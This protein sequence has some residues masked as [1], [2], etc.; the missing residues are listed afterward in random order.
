MQFRRRRNGRNAG[1]QPREQASKGELSWQATAAQAARGRSPPAFSRLPF[2]ARCLMK[3]MADRVVTVHAVEILVRVGPGRDR[4]DKVTVTMQA[5]SLRDPA[6]PRLDLNRLVEVSHR[7]GPRM[8]EPIIGLGDPFPDRIVREVAI[9]ADGHMPVARL[10]PRIEMSL[11]H[12]TIHAGLRVVTQVARPFSIAE[13]E[14]PHA[15]E[16]PCGNGH[17]RHDYRAAARPPEFSKASPRRSHCGLLL[18][19]KTHRIG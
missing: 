11:H 16:Q 9:V 7:E 5:G 8:K 12:V 19:K 3:G 6:I 15:S 14:R 1:K 4:M 2:F 13:R 17:Y 10:L 18:V